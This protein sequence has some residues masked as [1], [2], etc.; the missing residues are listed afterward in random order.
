MFLRMLRTSF[1]VYFKKILLKD[2]EQ[3][4]DLKKLNHMNGYMEWI[5]IHYLIGNL[6]VHSRLIKI[7]Q[8]TLII[9]YFKHLFKIQWVN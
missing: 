1:G 8:E 2:L 3:T 4:Q 6:K 9:K 5:G 7:G